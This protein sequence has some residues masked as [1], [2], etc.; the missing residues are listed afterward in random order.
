MLKLGITDSQNQKI[1][2]SGRKDDNL[3]NLLA[4]GRRRVDR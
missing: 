2:S 3:C 4:V 1:D